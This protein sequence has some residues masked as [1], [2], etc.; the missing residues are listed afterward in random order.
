MEENEKT[1]KFLT[2]LIALEH[3]YQVYRSH[4]QVF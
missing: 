1:A 4:Q 3:S 2:R